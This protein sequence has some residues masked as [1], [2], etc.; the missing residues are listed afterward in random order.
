VA[1]SA[2]EAYVT[3][4]NQDQN[5]P[6]T[7]GAYQTTCGITGNTRCNN[8]FVTK[9]NM[10]GSGLVWS[11]M[12]G[13]QLNG[14]NVGVNNVGPILL[15]SARNVY[16]TGTSSGTAGD[17]PQVNPIQAST[18]GNSPFITEFNPSGSEILFSTFFGAGGLSN[19]QTAAGLALDGNGYAYLAGNT[20]ASGVAVTAGAFQ[21]NFVGTNDGYVAKICVLL[22]CPQSITFNGLPNV[23]YGISPITLGATASSDLAV[24][25][26]VTGP[27]T[28]NGSTLTIE[29]AGQVSVTASQAGTANYLPATPMTQSFTVSPAVLT[30]TATSPSIVTGQ[31]I[32]GLTYVLS[33]FVNGDT[34]A[35]VSGAPSESTTA[36]AVSAPGNYPVT[37][38]LGTLS[39]AN[40]TFT[41][42]DGA[43]TIGAFTACDVN[44]HG[45]SDVS[46]VQELVNEALGIAPP[47]NSL[48]GGGAVNLVDAQIVLNAVLKLGCSRS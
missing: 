37:I 18:G 38:A 33:G 23:T 1:D 21:Q 24:S 41:P 45:K 35:L 5:F 11:T 2:G 3:G 10:T 31:A 27:A 8:A 17:F 32:P 9:L 44:Q 20:S 39:A 42:V 25:Y 12:L 7:E 48:Q 46:D 47:L 22:Q 14:A 6:V 29:G 28:A 26:G 16:V 13:N 4:V 40:Y 19:S 15:D 43:L 36:T 34:A 30:V